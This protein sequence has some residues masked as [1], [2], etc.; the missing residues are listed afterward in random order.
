M[1]RRPVLTDIKEF[2]PATI[3]IIL[4][5]AIIETIGGIFLGALSAWYSGSW[6][7]S[8]VRIVAYLGVVTPAFVWAIIFMLLFGY[9]WP[10]LPYSGPNR[11]RIIIPPTITGLLT[12]DSL[13][14]GKLRQAFKSAFHAFDFTF[15]CTCS[16]GLAQAA[17]ITR[18]SMTENLSKDYVGSALASGIPMRDGNIEI[19][20]EDHHLYRLLLLS[21]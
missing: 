7:D 18:T 19:C 10:I 6:F 8:V 1:T 15:F 20:T 21:H 2:L 12:V 3:E 5:A 4:L 16:C 11:F 17:R 13:I 9:I 14:T